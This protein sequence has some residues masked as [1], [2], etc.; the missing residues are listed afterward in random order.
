MTSTTHTCACCGD[1][2]GTSFDR[3]YFLHVTAAAGLVAAFPRLS[4]GAEGKY[5]A[6]LLACIDPRFPE[7]TIKYMEKRHMVGKYSQFTVAGA[8]IGVVAPAFKDWAKTF[9]D[10]LAASI[11][12]H[13]IG[14]VI[15]M[16]HRDCAAAKIAYGADKVAN[17]AIEAE[18]HKAALMEFRKQ[19]GQRHPKLVVETGL[20]A[21]NGKVEMFA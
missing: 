15:A 17:A 16:D 10:N 5:D 3:R 2:L 4:F 9:W 1:F 11:E 8:A 20:M 13:A 18:T 14:R 7:P 19:V 12:L 21:P 6:M